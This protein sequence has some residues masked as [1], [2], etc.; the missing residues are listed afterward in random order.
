MR[1]QLGRSPR[2]RFTV[3]LGDPVADRLCGRPELAAKREPLFI[4]ERFDGARVN[5]P[6]SLDQRF[7]MQRSGHQR[8]AR[9]GG[10]IQDDVLLL[11]QFKDRGFL[12]GIKL[13]A[14]AFGVFE[15]L[16]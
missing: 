13:Q 8:F 2:D 11:E 3:S 12:G 6:F 10:G 9:A 7:E 1:S 15:K 14:L 5:R 4:H 16:A